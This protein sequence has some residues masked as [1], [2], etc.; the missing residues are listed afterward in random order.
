[1]SWIGRNSALTQKEME[2]NADII[3]KYYRNNKYDDNTIAALLGNMQAESTINPNRYEG[4]VGPGYGLVQWTPMS[5]LTDACNILL[6]YPYTDGNVQLKVI[7]SEILNNPQAVAQWYSS[8]AFISKYYNSGASSDMIGITGTQ[9][10]HNDM[11][12]SADKLAILFMAA[13]ERPSY[14]P[15][16]NHYKLRQQYALKWFEYM[17]GIPPTPIETK[18]IKKYP[19]VIYSKKLRNKSQLKC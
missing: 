19:W 16:V 6:L 14:D 8:S 2:N 10:L 5:N 4:G 17:G 18:K 3:I 7:V 11:K 1:M 12:W 13:Y 9:F 15:D